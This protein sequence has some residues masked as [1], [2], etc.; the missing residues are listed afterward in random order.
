MNKSHELLTNRIDDRTVKHDRQLVRHVDFRDRRE[1]LQIVD[2][3]EVRSISIGA[4][5]IIGGRHIDPAPGAIERNGGRVVRDDDLALH[6]S[7]VRIED[8]AASHE[9]DRHE[10]VLAGLG[11]GGHPAEFRFECIPFRGADGH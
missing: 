5:G 10:P 9:A 1:I 3:Q 2:D 6:L 8:V 4:T 7:G 11:H